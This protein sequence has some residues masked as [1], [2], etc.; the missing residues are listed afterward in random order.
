MTLVQHLLFAGYIGSIVLADLDAP[1]AADPVSAEYRH[2]LVVNIP[3]CDV[4]T[5]DELAPYAGPSP[6]SGSG[7]HRYVLFVFK[8]S[9]GKQQ[10]E[11]VSSENRPNQNLRDFVKKWTLGEPVAGDFF[12]VKG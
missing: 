3:G 9:N 2:W 8:Q 5:G 12:K 6:P 4:T 10:F 11:G 7:L 1:S